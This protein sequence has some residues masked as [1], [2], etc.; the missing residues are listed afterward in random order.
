VHN[1]PS[2]SSSSATSQNAT[3]KF[4]QNAQKPSYSKPKNERHLKSPKLLAVV[5]FFEQK[6][7]PFI[8]G[9]IYEVF[10]DI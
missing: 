3:I 8:Q 5:P 7:A 6:S 9:K 2:S 1:P 4:S 10:F